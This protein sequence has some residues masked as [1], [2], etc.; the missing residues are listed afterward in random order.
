M[1]LAF[2]KTEKKFAVIKQFLT[3]YYFN[4]ENEFY[5]YINKKGKGHLLMKLKHA[6][7][8]KKVLVFERG[9]CDLKKF[10]EIRQLA[11]TPLTTGEILYIAE[12][13][14]NSMKELDEIDVYLCDNK[15]PNILVVM[16]SESAEK[17]HLT[18]TDLGG[19]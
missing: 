3:E 10:T 15:P 11:A 5:E 16:D 18:I 17:Y 7:E 19:A 4:V 2:D 13:M 12:Y 9:D 6:V 1:N 14:I 8:E